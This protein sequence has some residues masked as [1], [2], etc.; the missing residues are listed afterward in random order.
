MIFLP[1]NADLVARVKGNRENTS[2]RPHRR[3]SSAR[4]G[5]GGVQA[6]KYKYVSVPSVMHIAHA[7]TPNSTIYTHW[8]HSQSNQSECRTHHPRPRHEKVVRKSHW[9]ISRAGRSRWR[10][11]RSIVICRCAFPTA[12]TS[13][14]QPSCQ[15]AC[16][17]KGCCKD[18]LV[19]ESHSDSP[20][21]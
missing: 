18:G 13:V 11:N 10:R 8:G 19:G 1:E 6:T 3:G 7:H 14:E 12:M 5:R 9:W 4:R 16:G 17:V 15:T 2:A 21:F 20:L